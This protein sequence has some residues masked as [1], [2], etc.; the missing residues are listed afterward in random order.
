MP[1]QKTS[2][3][4]Q[5]S[6]D[7]EWYPKETKQRRKKQGKKAE[8]QKGLEQKRQLYCFKCGKEIPPDH[9]IKKDKS[10]RLSGRCLH[11]SKEGCQRKTFFVTKA[12]L[13][14]F[15]FKPA[16][17]IVK[18]EAEEREKLLRDPGF[19][20]KTI[21]EVQNNGVSG[22][23][24]TIIAE[25]I[26][27]STRLVEGA[28]AESK[29]LFLSDKTGI[30]KDFL[31]KKTL[32]VILPE[33]Q[34]LHVT[35]LSKEAFTYWHAF[36][37][38][39]TWDNKVIHFEDIPQ[40]ILNSDTFKVMSSGGSHAIV[41][42]D[43]KTID[44][45]IKGK[46]VMIITSHHA[47]PRDEALRRF[48]IGPLDETLKQTKR[49]KDKISKRF[50]GEEQNKKN[51]VLRSIIQNLKPYSVVIPFAGLI[52]HFF[53]ED[54]LMRTHYERF[55]VYIC[56]SAVFHQPQR[57]K[58]RDGKL[59]ATPDDYMIAR[60]VLIYT[61]SN[62]KMIPMSTEYKD[63]LQVLKENVEAMSVNEIFLKCDHSKKWLYEHL[64]SLTSTGLVIKNKR[65]SDEANREIDTYQFADVNPYAIPT[66]NEI[67]AKIERIIEKTGNTE[68]CE[69]NVTEETEFKNWFFHNVKIAKKPNS[70]L[71]ILHFS[72]GKIPLNG[73]VFSVFPKIS[74]F[75]RER[76]EKRYRKYYEEM[77]LALHEKLNHL[78]KF[79][80]DN[81]NAG[82]KIGDGFLYNNFDHGF[83]S[84]CIESSL[85]VKQSNGEY[86][87]GG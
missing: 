63:V 49:I 55:L 31:T 14:E 33:K 77:D 61:T 79:I 86:V 38:G 28:S 30:G 41:V 4:S 62:P 26:I 59:I 11:K 78:K 29:N 83:I 51:H 21:N 23:E 82:Y 10:G 35:K 47:N 68:K 76:D 72:G 75:L 71:V 60:L 9:P 52:Q 46:P 57:E 3:E 27:A 20:V 40:S 24:D 16:R 69:N 73:K 39:W 18:E 32:E 2:N 85:L 80:L 54:I 8:Q 34:H 45:P 1:K 37:D 87:F 44:I 22:E 17:E 58:N 15:D 74:Y 5:E 12:E 42:K 67:V 50:A 66:W 6:G 48:P 36:E 65:K 19:L 81:R 64:P 43:Q 56:S 84:Q 70:T 25:I 53:P 7:L 13:K